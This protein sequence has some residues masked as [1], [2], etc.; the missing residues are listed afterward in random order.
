MLE[1]NGDNATKVKKYDEALATYSIALSLS[2]SPPNSTLIKWVRVTLVCS[3]VDEASVLLVKDG[4]D[5]R[6]NQ[7]EVLHLS[8]IVPG[9]DLYLPKSRHRGTVNM[10]LGHQLKSQGTELDNCEGDAG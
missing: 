4:D 1:E 5:P 3:S 9:F 2:L 7:K 6:M 8:E 10:Q